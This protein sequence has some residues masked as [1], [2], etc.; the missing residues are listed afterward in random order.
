MVTFL[1]TSSL[2]L[3]SWSEPKLFSIILSLTIA[4][5]SLCSYSADWKINDQYIYQISKKDYDKSL[6]IELKDSY[7]NS[8]FQFN[9]DLSAIGSYQKTKSHGKVI[10]KDFSLR[11]AGSLNQI[12]LGMINKNLG[13]IDGISFLKKNESSVLVN[14]ETIKS[15]ASPALFYQYYGESKFQVL[16]Q[17]EKNHSLH[18]NKEDGIW[19]PDNRITNLNFN[20]VLLLLPDDVVFSI[21][22]DRVLEASD[23]NNISLKWEKS[24]S[25]I[26]LGLY[27]FYGTSSPS[28]FYSFTASVTNADG[29]VITAE[30]E[31]TILPTYFK[32]TAF[33]HFGSYQFDESIL[34]WELGI[35]KDQSDISYI[36]LNETNFQLQYEWSSYHNSWSLMHFVIFTYTNSKNDLTYKLSPFDLVYALRLIGE[37]PWS[38]N[39]RVSKSFKY[40]SSGHLYLSENYQIS[41]SSNVKLAYMHFQSDDKDLINMY[42][43]KQYVSLEFEYLF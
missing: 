8:S 16:L 38:T 27:A 4:L 36:D 23:K 40:S 32:E 3:Q 30:P 9:Y 20:D 34:K 31:I 24:F 7:E 33:A 43:K 5:T 1:K 6:A 42:N 35:R 15:Q 17:F 39:F 37:S 28:Y 22:K 2:N 29:S 11:Y 12:E 18:L 14:P 13:H 26:D 25:N 19:Y 21:D 41:D 10:V